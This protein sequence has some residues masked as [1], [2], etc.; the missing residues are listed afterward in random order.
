LRNG[1]YKQA[2]DAFDKDIELVPQDAFITFEAM[3]YDCR[4]S[5]ILLIREELLII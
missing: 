2:I 1:K 3:M 4:Y 5:K